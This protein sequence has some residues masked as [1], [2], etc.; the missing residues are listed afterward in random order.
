MNNLIKEHCYVDDIPHF[1]ILVNPNYCMN[2]N[3]YNVEWYWYINT[4]ITGIFNTN[5]LKNT[6]KYIYS[7]NNLRSLYNQQ[8][9]VKSTLSL[10]I[11]GE[12]KNIIQT[13]VIILFSLLSLSYLLY[14]LF[15]DLILLSFVLD[16]E[17]LYVLL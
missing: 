2:S 7:I 8:T 1:V 12:D 17:C 6:N 11:S 5:S 14:E 4:P 16:L 15:H 10:I 3:K 9:A 13:A